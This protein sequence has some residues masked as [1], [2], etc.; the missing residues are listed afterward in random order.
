MVASKNEMVDWLKHHTLQDMKSLAQEM[1]DEGRDV[2]DL[3]EV[4]KELE[5]ISTTEGIKLKQ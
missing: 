3:V 5:V 4:I 2:R 1:A